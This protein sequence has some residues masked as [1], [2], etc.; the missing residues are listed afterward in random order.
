MIAWLSLFDVAALLY[1]CVVPRACAPCWC[2]P[3]KE[4]PSNRKRMRSEPPTNFRRISDEPPTKRQPNAVTDRDN[5]GQM[6][7]VDDSNDTAEGAEI[8]AGQRK[9]KRAPPWRPASAPP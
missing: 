3:R 2:L 6:V 7:T 5:R 4:A 1:L 8:V 9:R